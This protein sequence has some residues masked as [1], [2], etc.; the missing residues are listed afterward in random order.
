MG[1]NTNKQFIDKQNFAIMK[2]Q[3]FTVNDLRIEIE[4]LELKEA[5]QTIRVKE[6]TQVT[7]E[8]LQPKALVKDIFNQVTSSKTVKRNTIDGVLGIG[9]GLLVKNIIGFKSVGVLKKLTS[10]AMQFATTKL[11]SGNVHKVISKIIQLKK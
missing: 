3:L 11:V 5:E 7:L 2:R 9:A 1:S 10:I 8:S 4:K 6:L